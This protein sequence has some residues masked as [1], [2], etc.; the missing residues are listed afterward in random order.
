MG[1]IINQTF[2]HPGRGYHP[3]MSV[4]GNIISQKKKGIKYDVR[5]IA[6]SWGYVNLQ[7]SPH[8]NLEKSNKEKTTTGAVW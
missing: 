3:L 5:I 1:G 4:V 6:L 7:L 2:L 8:G